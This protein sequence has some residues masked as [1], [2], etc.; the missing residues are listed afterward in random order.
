MLGLKSLQLRRLHQGLIYAYKII[1][2]SSWSGFFYVFSFV[3]VWAMTLYIARLLLKVKVVSQSQ[4]QGLGL[5]LGLSKLTVLTDGHH[6]HIELVLKWLNCLTVWTVL[7][8]SHF[9]LCLHVN[10]QTSLLYYTFFLCIRIFISRNFSTLLALSF[11]AFSVSPLIHS[12][13]MVATCC[14]RSHII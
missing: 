7:F 4:H 9:G 6:F 13:S 3:C 1:F 5:E 2:W 14:S 11:L 8:A 12:C 10:W